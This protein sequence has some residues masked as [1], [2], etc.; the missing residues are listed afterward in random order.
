MTDLAPAAPNE[1][2]EA[3]DTIRGVAL[4]GI[5]IIN[6]LAFGLPFRAQFDPTVDGSTTGVDF[7]A[8]FAMG[9]VFEG[10]MRAL[11]SML[12][13]AGIAMVAASGKGAAIHYRRQLLLLAIG[14]IDAFVLL[15]TGDILVPYAL[16]GMVLY[17]ARNWPPRGLFI[18]AGVV[19]AYL[20][21]CYGSFYL[22]LTVVPEQAEAVQVRLDAGESIT[23][24]ER[25]MLDGWREL[26]V[27]IEPTP[28]LLERERLKFE[29][30]YWQ[31]VKANAGE[32]IDLYVFAL[33]YFII[34]DAIACMLLGMALFKVGFLTG[35]RSQGFYLATAVLGFGI[36]LAV[37]GFEMAMKIATDYAPEW[38]SGASVPTNDLGRVCMALGFVSAVMIAGARGYLAKLRRGLAAVGRMALS[39][40]ILQSL[41]GIV[42]F[43][44]MGFGLWNELARHELYYVVFGQWLVMI[45]FSVWWLDRYRFGPLEWL[46]RTL[47]YG[48]RQPMALHGTGP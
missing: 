1:R 11:F 22:M 17:F 30:S 9:F 32:V 23:T 38:V 7:A 18:A 47:T 26:E 10:A 36:G 19:F 20:V 48:R 15:W 44:D 43:H 41:F 6:I 25:A 2:I 46:W 34:W 5:L 33:P 14:L 3:I 29:G 45:A 21:I 12:F 4:L 24:E 8:Y 16:A 27:N 31:S 37:N 42:I 13:G 28:G 39:N 35:Q 40:Y